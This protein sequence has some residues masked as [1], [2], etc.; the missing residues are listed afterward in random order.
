MS[1]SVVCG[2]RGYWK[3][4]DFVHAVSLVF[5]ERKTGIFFVFLPFFSIAQSLQ[6]FSF[7]F[8]FETLS[9][10][11]KNIFPKFSNSKR[12]GIGN[13]YFRGGALRAKYFVNVAL[14]SFELRYIFMY[15]IF[16]ATFRNNTCSSS[17][18]D[19]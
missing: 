9:F 1:S 14:G 8:N 4:E 7:A 3:R 15:V 5:L 11:L 18:G 12:G 16:Q 17:P 2:G 13:G 6:T 10:E 19:E